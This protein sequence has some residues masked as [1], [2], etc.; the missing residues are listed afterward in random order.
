MK[1]LQYYPE[2]NIKCRTGQIDVAIW[3]QNRVVI[4]RVNKHVDC[5][6]N[7]I[8]EVSSH[9]NEKLSIFE[10]IMDS[11]NKIPVQASL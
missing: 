8:H 10:F 5:Y 4:K 11:K 9:S 6:K 1:S 7:F 2:S 3:K